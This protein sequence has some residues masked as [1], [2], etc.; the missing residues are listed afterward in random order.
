MAGAK[1]RR[2]LH[3]GVLRAEYESNLFTSTDKV[4]ENRQEW[5]ALE[6]LVVNP[7]NGVTAVLEDGLE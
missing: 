2:A 4:S 5:I 7:V 1:T 6:H 3:T